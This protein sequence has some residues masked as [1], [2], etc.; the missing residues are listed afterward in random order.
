MIYSIAVGRWTGLFALAWYADVYNSV[1][2]H[3]IATFNGLTKRS[4]RAKAARYVRRLHRGQGQP[5][6]TVT[7]YA[8]DVA[9]DSLQELPLISGAETKTEVAK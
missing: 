9:K 8:Y 2:Q 5:G 4:A 3:R 6:Q 7:L 1:D